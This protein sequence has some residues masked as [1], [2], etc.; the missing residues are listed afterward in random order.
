MKTLFCLLKNPGHGQQTHLYKELMLKLEVCYFQ[1]HRLQTTGLMFLQSILSCPWQI[2]KAIMY[3][4]KYIKYYINYIKP[5]SGCH[6]CFRYSVYIWLTA[7]SD[8]LSF[9]YR[10][11]FLITMFVMFICS[12]NAFGKI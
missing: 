12:S 4:V 10:F 8:E 6:I 9:N 1:K 5:G 2:H 3:Y 11:I 7:A